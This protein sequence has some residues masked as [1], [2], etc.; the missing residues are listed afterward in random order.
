M[1]VPY[2]RRPGGSIVI[3]HGGTIDGQLSIPHGGGAGPFRRSYS[4]RANGGVGK[5]FHIGRNGASVISTAAP[6]RPD[7]IDHGNFIDHCRVADIIYIIV[8]HI[9]IGY[10]VAGTKI[11]VIIR[12]PVAGERDTDIDMRPHGSPAIITSVFS[13]GDPCRGP[14]ITGRPHPSIRVVIKPV[15][16]MKCSPAPA[17]IGYPGPAI[18]RIDQVPPGPIWTEAFP[19]GRHPDI[20]IAGIFDP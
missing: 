17:I 10:P 8:A 20:A 4:H 16:I 6:T 13:P 3:L 19:A 11:P 7:I 14:F 18:F 5:S 9:Y 2:L 15:A 12:R 1:Q